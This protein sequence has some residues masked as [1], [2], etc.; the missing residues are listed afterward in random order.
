LICGGRGRGERGVWGRAEASPQLSTIN[1]QGA[2]SEKRGKPG[3]SHF[4]RSRVFSSSEIVR[5]FVD[6]RKGVPV[7]GARIYPQI[8][9]SYMLSSS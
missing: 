7:V 5:G 6:N 2:E 8:N 1:E 4:L 3:F 9:P